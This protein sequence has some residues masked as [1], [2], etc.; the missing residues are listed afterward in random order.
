M[1][2]A[3]IV[4]KGG[5]GAGTTPPSFT[6]TGV[7]STSITYTVTNNH[8]T[9]ADIYHELGGTSPSIQVLNVAA[10]ATITATTVS[11][12]TPETSYVIHAFAV[13]DGVSP[14]PTITASQ[15]TNS[16]V[17]PTITFISETSSS[18][19]FTI[20]NN[21]SVTGQYAFGTTDT[22]I[23]PLTNIGAGV[24]TGNLTISGLAQS[25]ENTIYARVRINGVYSAS[26][27]LTRTLPEVFAA[28]GGTKTSTGSYDVH[29]FTTSGTFEITQG[30]NQIEYLV[31]AGGGNGGSGGGTSGGGGAGGYR[32]SVPGQLSGRSSS[33][34]TPLNLGVGSYTV[35]VGGGNANSVFATITSTKGGV[36][37]SGGLSSPVGESG[38]SGGGGGTRDGGNNPQ[39]GGL[40]IDG[41]GGNGGNA[42]SSQGAGGG[43]ASTNAGTPTGA[44][45]L[46]SNITGTEVIRAGGGGGAG[47]NI[48]LRGAGGAGGGGIGAQYSNT[49]GG[50]AASGTANTGSG[51]G[52]GSWGKGPGGGGSGIVIVR[53]IRKL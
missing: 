22:P 5:G 51:G 38:G 14:S 46:S 18:I 43:G 45:G 41:Q 4:R 29:T 40:G 36:G 26:V 15:T 12:L 39:V 24:T 28:T 11:S 16:P 19:T 25:Q 47:G 17:T 31:I 7:T 9:A 13:A 33:A 2:E 49:A 21:D 32:S 23:S 44:A 30:T 52:G 1:G 10:G 48:N 42:N 50:D 34:E 6:I 27:S 37:G 35:T 53:Y 3:F 20:R 8:T